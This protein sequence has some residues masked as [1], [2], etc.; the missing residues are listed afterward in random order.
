MPVIAE[1]MSVPAA[2]LMI[3]GHYDKL[4]GY[5]T[6]RPAGSPSWLLLWTQAGAG[7]VAQ[8][9]APFE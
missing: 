4:P 3:V 2:E 1:D 8:G 5:A 7:T 9:G 6:R